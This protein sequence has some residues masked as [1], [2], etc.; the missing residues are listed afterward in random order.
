MSQNSNV[1]A[2]KRAGV[3][4]WLDDLSRHRIESGNLAELINTAG[5]V[6]VTTNPAIFA[7][8]LKHDVSYQQALQSMQHSGLS[9]AETVETLMCED[10]AAACDIFLRTYRESDGVD[11]RVSIEVSPELAHDAS[12]TVAAGL[13]LWKKID[14]PNLMI[15]VPATE[16]CLPAISELLSHGVSVN[17]TLIFSLERYRAVINAYLVGIE[18]ARARGLDV[19]QIHSVASF[20]ISRMDSHVDPLLRAIGSDRAD[21]LVGKTAVAN[22][23]LAYEIFSEMFASERAAFILSQGARRQRLLW[24]S[25]GVKDESLPETYYV[26]E[27]TE[28]DTVNTMPEATLDAV[29]GGST[30]RDATLFR[31][32][33]DAHQALNTLA[34]LGIN[35][36]EVVETLEAEGIRKFVEANDALLVSAA[37]GMSR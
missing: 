27:L 17:V 7:A 19:S 5:I 23:R 32:T 10:V 9:V 28:A 14:K 30:L 1:A 33:P 37:K 20:F 25:T 18:Q 16:E 4:I 29:L 31:E 8:A 6:G 35:Y 11:G 22:A 34:D 12:A 21:T 2:L 3:S 13:H 26:E 36:V 15:K 24:A